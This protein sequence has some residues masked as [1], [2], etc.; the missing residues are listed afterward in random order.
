MAAAVAT[1]LTLAEFLALP[2]TE[3]A[4]E[5]IRGEVV[6]KSMPSYFHSAIIIRLIEI[7]GPY[8]RRS[9]LGRLM[10][11]VRHADNDEERAYLPDVGVLLRTRRLDRETKRVGPIWQTPDLAI[12]VLSPDDRPGRVAEK[13]AFYLRAGVPLTWVIDPDELTLDAYRPGQ[14]TEQFVMRGTVSAAPVLPDFSLDLAELFSVL[15]ED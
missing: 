2:E 12:E 8:L 5:F 6:Q 4:S 11:E 3:P 9:E 10:T 14:P 15:E 7:L 13:V 1:R